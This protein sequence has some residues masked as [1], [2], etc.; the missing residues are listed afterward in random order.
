MTLTEQNAG[1]G[2]QTAVN[3]PDDE[4]LG[5]A[6]RLRAI[7]LEVDPGSLPDLVR[8]AGTGRDRALWSQSNL[9][10]LG[11][12]TALKLTLRPGWADASETQL[13]ADALASIVTAEP[14]GGPGTGPLAM[15]SLPYD[16]SRS[17]H[18]RIPRLVLG[19][20]PDAAWATFVTPAD[21]A[22]SQTEA[23]RVLGDE[24][25]QLCAEARPEDRPD[26]FSLAAS[27]SHDQWRH[28]VRSAVAE[29][30][31]G[32]FDKVVLARK[33]DVTANRPFVLHDILA[34]LASLYPSCAVFH[35][36]GFVGASP[37]TLVRRSGREIL[38]HPLAGTVA[39][40]GDSGTDEAL[41]AQLMAS[42]KDRWEH[43][44][45]VDAIVARLA[46]M[47]DRLEV[48]T[49]P[50]VLA[51]RNV[52]HLGTALTGTLL[53]EPSS[54]RPVPT[55]L[56]LAAT[57]Q[58]TPAVGGHPTGPA[59]RWQRDNEGFDR[60]HYAG[61]VG[62]TDARGDGEWALGLRSA[63]LSGYHAALYAGSGIVVG[64]DPDAELAETQLKLQALLAALV[65]P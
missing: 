15:G 53:G 19:Q 38:S 45:V 6:K 2:P 55:S 54:G 43:Q 21:A 58:P 46:P 5:T 62:W 65:R 52:S 36:D 61:P 14:G 26:A 1:G 7:T 18:L 35:F 30:E 23:R 44:L 60:G 9:C 11:V 42:G 39:R 12:G 64:S 56:Q 8:A 16:P 10:L 49:T 32:A 3:K 4:V 33:V 41:L 27:M 37:E 25:S 31:L 29:M 51:L 20:R 28:V 40:S 50:S 59:L 13:V 57:L 48:P 34:R 22:L 24:L 47:C 63:D 17:G